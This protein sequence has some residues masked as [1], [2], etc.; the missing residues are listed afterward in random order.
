LDYL[1]CE[2]FD[3]AVCEAELFFVGLALRL[4]V[5]E[6]MVGLLEGVAQVSYSLNELLP[7]S[8]PLVNILLEFVV[9]ALH[10]FLHDAHR[11]FKVLFG[12]LKVVLIVESIT[13]LLLELLE[14]PLQQL[15]LIDLLLKPDPNVIHLFLHAI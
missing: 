15:E 2:G 11:G 10:V 5:V 14:F 13:M 8:L 6:F 7:F 9:D 12:G 4:C 3:G 1:A